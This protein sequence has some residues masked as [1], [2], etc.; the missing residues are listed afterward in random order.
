[1]PQVL[2]LVSDW[3]DAQ[4]RAD[5]A[6]T[7]RPCPEYLRLERDHGVE[8]LDWSRLGGRRPRRSARQ[9]LRH[10][11][12]AL[13]RLKGVDVLFSDGEHVGIPL[14]LAMMVMSPRRAIPHLMIGHHL[15][16]R[17]K[18]ALL[19]FSRA[20]RSITRIVVHSRCQLERAEQQLSIPASRIAFVPYFADTDFWQPL[21]LPEEDLIVS[22]GQEH[23]DYLTLARACAGFSERVFVARGSTYSPHAASSTPEERAGHLEF[24]F[25]D[26]RSLRRWYSRAAVVVVPLLSNDFQAGVTTLLEAMAMAK[27]VIVSATA[28]QR[29]IVEDGFTG[30]TVPPED[31]GELRRAIR[32][33]MTHSEERTR[34]GRNARR[35]VQERFNLSV[36]AGRLAEHLRVMAEGRPAA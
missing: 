1:M 15:T 28:G 20:H 2:M 23:R 22:A 31:A 21:P 26:Q 30:M 19:R 36:Y 8:V 13:Q 9:S 4:L 14:A 27:P 5:V 3:A 12:A 10:V 6:A 34:L 18:R 29:D 33:L 32:H 16:T 24:G 35:A 11:L 17:S 7:H 25:T